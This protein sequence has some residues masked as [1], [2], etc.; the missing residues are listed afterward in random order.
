[1]YVH[2]FLHNTHTSAGRDAH[3][4]AFETWA[5]RTF[6]TGIYL[7][8]IP[9]VG[10]VAMATATEVNFE[11]IGFTC[12]LVACLTT[13]TPFTHRPFHTLVGRCLLMR[14]CVCTAA[15]Q[16]VLSS[17]LLTGQYRLDS[18]NLLYYMVR[19]LTH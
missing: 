15:V 13:G 19:A 18:V 4:L 12:A 16:S 6:P 8:L 14:V 10:G 9:V 3:V 7:A 11:M 1:M 2:P 17:V 5:N